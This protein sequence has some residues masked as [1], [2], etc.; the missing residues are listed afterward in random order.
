MNLKVN[1][2]FLKKGDILI[3]GVSDVRTAFSERQ[4]KTSYQ[5]FD[6]KF[7]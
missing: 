2:V 4:I 1:D 3:D 6:M 5:M 7:K